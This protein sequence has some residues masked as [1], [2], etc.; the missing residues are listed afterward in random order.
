MCDFIGY[1]LK[2]KW[3]MKKI[4]EDLEREQPELEKA[5]EQPLTVTNR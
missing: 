5:Q 1:E 3:R 2:D 4:V